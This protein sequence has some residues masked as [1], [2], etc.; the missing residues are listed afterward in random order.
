MAYKTFT[1]PT[2]W[3]IQDFYNLDYILADHY[4]PEVMNEYEKSGHPMN[5]INVFKYH[6][7][8]P[9]P[10]CISYIKLLDLLANPIANASLI[11]S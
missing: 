4:D 11:F 10:E 1:I 7:S 5:R 8:K 2:K 3:N 9:M 6:D